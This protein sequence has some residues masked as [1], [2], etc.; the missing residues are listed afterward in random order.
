V[1]RAAGESCGAGEASMV[2]PPH[3]EVLH[4]SDWSIRGDDTHD[5]HF[6]LLGWE[7]GQIALQQVDGRK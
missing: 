5:S 2:E 6:A 4:Y 7:S 3:Y 1:E